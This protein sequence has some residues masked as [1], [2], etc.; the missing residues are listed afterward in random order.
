MS[1]CPQSRTLIIGAYIYLL[2]A[3]VIEQEIGNRLQNQSA[4]KILLVLRCT[5]SSTECGGYRC[6]GDRLRI[7]HG[8]FMSGRDGKLRVPYLANTESCTTPQLLMS[9]GNHGVD[10]D[11]IA[12][13]LSIICSNATRSI[14]GSCLPRFSA[15][16]KIPS[17]A[18]AL[19]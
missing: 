5:Y 12:F 13:S 1:L 18:F 19:K 8:V 2:T 10:R 16:R 4:N 17:Q 11:Y 7:T 6:E 9:C 14:L 3:L 15:L